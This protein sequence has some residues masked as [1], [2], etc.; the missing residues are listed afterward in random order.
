M[1]LLLYAF[2]RMQDLVP[3]VQ[4]KVNVY[5]VVEGEDGLQ[6]ESKELHEKVIYDFVKTRNY[7][8]QTSHLNFF[9]FQIILMNGWLTLYKEVPN[10]T[11]SLFTFF[12]YFFYFFYYILGVEF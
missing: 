1:I 12:Y 9:L 6:I 2:L 5:S 3:G 7:I 8:F 4:Y 10:E 11:D